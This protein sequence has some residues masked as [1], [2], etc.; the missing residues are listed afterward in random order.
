MT[1]PILA[2]D[3]STRTGWALWDRNGMV[4]SGV[5]ELKLKRGESPGMR[6]LRFRAWLTELIALGQLA[7]NDGFAERPAFGPG[8]IAYEQAHHRGGAATE[9]CVGLVAVVQEQAA[10]QRVEHTAV[11]TAELKKHATGK[12]NAGKDMMLE[13]ARKR[14]RKPNLQS[15]DE[16]D[17]LCI[18]DWAMEE[19]GEE[20]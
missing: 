13:A 20:R 10:R 19:I 3:L 11:H 9:L 18:L 16:A 7:P 14:W 1:T 6:F 5:Y 4:T 12:G 15:D 2:L 8:V 17:A